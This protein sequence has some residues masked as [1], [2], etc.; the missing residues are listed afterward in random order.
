MPS[1][2]SDNNLAIQITTETDNAG[3]EDASKGLKDLSDTG[4][5][6]GKSLNDFSEKFSS[7]MK[8][9]SIAT[10]L[11]GAGLTVY[12]KS[13]VDT[14]QELVKSS[15][16]LATQTGMTVTQSSTM[17]AVFKRLGVSA[18]QTSA[19]FRVFA[20]QIAASK[21]GTSEQTKANEELQ[22]KIKSL[23]TT[24]DELNLKIRSNEIQTAKYTEEIKNNGDK[25]GEL[26]NKIDKLHLSTSKYK[27]QLANLTAQTK[28]YQDKINESKNPLDQLNIA[29]KNADGSSRG[30]N[31]ILLDVSDKFKAMPNGVDKTTLAV[32]LFGRSGTGMI[33]VLNEGSDGIKKL[34]QQA[35]KLGL[36]LN[37]TNI[38]SISKYTKSQ[39]DLADST[40]ALKIQVGT[41]TAPVLTAF[42]QKINDVMIALINTH[43]PM[44]TA[45][46]DILAFGGPILGAIS[47][48]T[49][50]AANLIA[51]G[52]T[53]VS[54]AKW[55]KGIGVAAMANVPI[56]ATAQAE[57]GAMLAIPFVMPAIV[58]AA[59]LVALGVVIAKILETS[60]VM[61]QLQQQIDADT[62]N[63]NATTDDMYRRVTSATDKTKTSLQTL[64]NL[65]QSNGYSGNNKLYRDARSG[66]ITAGFASGGYT[67]RG[68][69]NEI[70]GIVHK[71]E[72]VVPQNQV[73]Q[74]TGMP[75]TTK[76]G[77]NVNVTQNIY[78]QI[79]YN[80]GISE[81]GW[82]LRNA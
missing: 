56:V 34:E 44:H 37:A 26:Q 24:H 3:V 60:A 25:S 27:D 40:T 8:K 81:I 78:N 43:G 48:I 35:D 59:A 74:N 82:R 52:P 38:E 64:Y 23:G 21:D 16:G 2:N 19:S 67:G 18:D 30:F 54:F 71:G 32:K 73:D 75:K 11:A 10:G 65:Q 17:L 80:K 57:I 41:L 76:A 51:A 36:T 12:S 53:V 31:D 20:K 15:K 6:T 61:R 47:G 55:V 68:G 77:A 29:T 14:L 39:K 69:E 46:V 63:I 58:V 62:K 13:A 7:G 22:Q 1:L 33:K 4:Q 5:E 42:N 66:T 45:V 28:D 50:F 49:A 72:Y 70:A 79:D 9:V